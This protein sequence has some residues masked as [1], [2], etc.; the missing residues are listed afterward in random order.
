[1]RVYR[2]TPPGTVEV[3]ETDEVVGAGDR[4]SVLVRPLDPAPAQWVHSPD[5][6]SWG[7][8]GSGPSEL[9]RALL[10]DHCGPGG[11]EPALYQAFKRD[12]VAGWPQDGPWE[13]EAPAIDA[14]LREWV[15]S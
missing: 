6:F 15:R 2:G 14:W 1:M 7:Y 10:V 9:A 5:G 3:W 13:L 4:R 8:G 11:G 12:V